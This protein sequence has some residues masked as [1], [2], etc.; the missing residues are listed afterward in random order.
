MPQQARIP[1]T[2][3]AREAVIRLRA[4]WGDRSLEGT[5]CGGKQTP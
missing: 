4:A 5:L 1:A 3:A 2:P